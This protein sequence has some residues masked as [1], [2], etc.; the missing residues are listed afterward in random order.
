MSEPGLTHIDSA[1]SARM[2][3]IGSTPVVVQVGDAE[4][5]ESYPELTRAAEVPVIDTSCTAL[6]RLARSVHQ[7]GYKVALTG[8]AQDRSL[9]PSQ[10][11]QGNGERDHANQCEPGDG[12]RH[13]RNQ[14]GR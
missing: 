1:G 8:V 12:G 3:D 4:V 13:H 9:R 6:L 5:L 11:R 7:N 14:L 2:V 10:A